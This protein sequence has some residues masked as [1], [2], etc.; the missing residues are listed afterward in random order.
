MTEPDPVTTALDERADAASIY[1]AEDNSSGVLDLRDNQA[2]WTAKQVAALKAL[3]IK[4][5]TQEDLL[6]FFHYCQR[7]GLDPFSKQIYLLE[8]KSWNKET[9]GYDYT[10]TIQVG[11]DGYRVRAQRA[12]LREGVRVDYEDTVW[13]DAEGKRH[14]VWLDREHPPT[15]CRVTVVKIYPDGLRTRYPGLVNFES[16]AAYGQ[17]RDKTEKWLLAQ[18]GVMPEH[19]IEKCA[20]AFGLRRAFPA[21]LGGMF[22]EEELQGGIAEPPP[23]LKAR[24]RGPTADDDF[25]V[26]GEAESATPAAQSATESSGPPPVAESLALIAASFRAHGLGANGYADI[27]HAVVTGFMHP[28]PASPPTALLDTDK[29]TPA[30]AQFL[31]TTL[32]EWLGGL[33]EQDDFSV[34]QQIIQFADEITAV[35]SDHQEGPK[36]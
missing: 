30:A 17:N 20:E 13:F 9:R 15:A 6:V 22:V 27:R 4:N 3:G 34:K 31:A 14:E 26:Q 1:S 35:I 18:W 2:W 5:A 21:D 16:Y 24:K 29:L 8:R 33:E 19:M 25:V 11:I 36:K 10:Q 23:K 7:T 32:A 12:A 28:D